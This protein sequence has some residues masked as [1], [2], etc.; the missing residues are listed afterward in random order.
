AA[1][2]LP[3]DGNDGRLRDPFDTRGRL[4]RRPGRR[5]VAA[6]WPRHADGRWRFRT[7]Q[8]RTDPRGDRVLRPRD[9]GARGVA[10]YPRRRCRRRARGPL[11]FTARVRSSL[12]VILPPIVLGVVFIAL[13]QAWVEI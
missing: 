5:D 4:S 9:R 11:K 8:E 6:P 13:W 7:G 2:D 12:A 10:R 1:E 3:R